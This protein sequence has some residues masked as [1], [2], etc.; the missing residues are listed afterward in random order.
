VKTPVYLF[1]LFL[2][3]TAPRV[4][5]AEGDSFTNGVVI[6]KIIGPAKWTPDSADP[7]F[8]RTKGYV[9]YFFTSIEIVETKNDFLNEFKGRRILLRTDAF[10]KNCAAKLFHSKFESRSRQMERK[11]YAL[12]AAI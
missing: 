11:L 1:V 6:A 4:A 5:L 7:G 8:P 12:C 2:I 9:E 10:D 3:A